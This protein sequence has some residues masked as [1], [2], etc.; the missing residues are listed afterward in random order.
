MHMKANMNLDIPK[1]C[2][3]I[4]INV[5]RNKNNH[6][7]LCP[8]DLI[9]KELFSL[10][11]IYLNSEIISDIL[12][13]L[14]YL[15]DNREF[16]SK[17][18]LNLTFIKKSNFE[19]INFLNQNVNHYNNN[20]NHI[21]INNFSVEVNVGTIIRILIEKYLDDLNSGNKIFLLKIIFNLFNFNN[22]LMH[23]E[24]LEPIIRCLGDKEE[25]C[26]ISALGIIYIFSQK[27]ENNFEIMKNNILFRI[28]RIYK[29]ANLEINKII[30]KIILNLFA[31]EDYIDLFFKNNIILILEN[32]FSS[33]EPDQNEE[34]VTTVF[35]IFK[36]SIDRLDKDLLYKLFS[37]ALNFAQ[38]SKFKK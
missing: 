36:I 16:I 29:Y 21:S 1:E 31:K 15:T 24:S 19:E 20:N 25:E 6:Y 26:I 12:N 13:V 33:F 32:L 22:N 37:K 34:T 23:K 17:L 28:F 14:L 4:F 27:S 3:K 38:N 30:V 2:C 10:I 9:F 7:K 5:T 11:S 8:E 35:E 18:S